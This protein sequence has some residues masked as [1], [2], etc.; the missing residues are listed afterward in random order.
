MNK[1][2]YEIVK[3]AIEG[4][5]SLLIVSKYHTKEEILEYHSLG[6]RHFGENRAQELIGKASSLPKDIHWHFIGH[7]QKDKVKKVVPI[8]DIIQSVDSIELAEKINKESEKINKV[9]PILVELHLAK[10]DSNKTGMDEEEL[11]PFLSAVEGMKNINL[12]GLMVMGPL[13]D[14]KERIKE[15]FKRGRTIFESMQKRYGEETITIY[16]AG[17]SND[18]PLALEEGSNQIRLGNFLF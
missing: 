17:M 7:L 13:T 14:D 16:S 9:M 8:V 18:Y 2:H 4:R 12:K 5:A 11:E 15:V 6:E 1:S 3:N 10:E